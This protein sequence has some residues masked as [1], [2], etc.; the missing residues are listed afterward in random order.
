MTPNELKRFLADQERKSYMRFLT[1]GS[2]DDGKSTLI[3]RLLYDTKLIF[4][5]QLKTLEKDS[6]KHGTWQRCRSGAV[7]RRA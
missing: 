3:G 1:C 6:R 4:E 2:V 5:D 7:V